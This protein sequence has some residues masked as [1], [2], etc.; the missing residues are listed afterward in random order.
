[1]QASGGCN[2]HRRVVTSKDLVLVALE[3]GILGHLKHSARREDI[4]ASSEAEEERER[5]HRWR[6]VGGEKE[7]H[8]TK[9]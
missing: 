2:L 3:N 1:M 8:A 6:Y 5:T 7:P 4:S 9:G